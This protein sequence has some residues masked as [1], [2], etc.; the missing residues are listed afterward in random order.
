MAQQR[1]PR[2]VPTGGRFA[3]KHHAE[4]ELGQDL[5]HPANA[6]EVGKQYLV[7]YQLTDEYGEVEERTAEIVYAGDQGPFITSDDGSMLRR[8]KIVGV[9]TNDPYEKALEAHA[10]A[11]IAVYEAA[12]AKVAQIARNYE[13]QAA[14]V[15]FM[16]VPDGALGNQAGASYIVTN[17]GELIYFD[18]ETA[19]FDAQTLEAMN[20]Y[21]QALTE[22]AGED[23]GEYELELSTGIL[24]DAVTADAKALASIHSNRSS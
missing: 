8:D 6:L 2:G 14:R 10:K 7:R 5:D 22:S 24:D 11:A 9:E 17:R 20:E 3:S 16:V 15:G 18:D 12:V 4:A 19:R 21:L 13:P 23:A 1:D